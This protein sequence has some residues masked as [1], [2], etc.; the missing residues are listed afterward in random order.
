MGQLVTYEMAMALQTVTSA[1]ATESPMAGRGRSVNARAAA[2]GPIIR[3]KIRKAPTT[4]T[5]MAVATARTTK[6]HISMR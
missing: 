4:G 6:K 1:M 3:L 5:V 2:G